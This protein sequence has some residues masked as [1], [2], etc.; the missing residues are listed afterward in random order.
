MKG[1]KV[2]GKRT[3]PK[4]KTTPNIRYADNKDNKREIK[5]KQNLEKFRMITLNA[6]AKG[7]ATFFVSIILFIFVGSLHET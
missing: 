3:T 5:T 2:K 6:C 7:Y 1:I 4:I